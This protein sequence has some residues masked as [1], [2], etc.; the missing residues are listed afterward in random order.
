[1][2]GIVHI[3]KG[4]T[5]V[6]D[7]EH[8]YRA[9][10]KRS[11]PE[12]VFDE[13]RV[14]A[15]LGD[16]RG[17]GV[18]MQEPGF[19]R[20]MMAMLAG[21]KGCRKGKAVRQ[22]IISLESMPDA[23]QAVFYSA[24]GKLPDAAKN[25]MDTFAPGC[26]WVAFVH[27]DRHHPH[28]HVVFENWDYKHGGRRLDLNPQLLSKMQDMKWCAGLGIES[29]K[30]SIGRVIDGQKLD[31][32]G[33]DLS[34]AKTWHER[35][36]LCA[37]NAFATRKDAA[38]ELLHWCAEKKPDKTVESLLDALCSGPLPPGWEVKSKTKS[39]GDLRKPSVKIGGATLRLETFLDVFAA[40]LKP[41]G[42]S[43]EQLRANPENVPSP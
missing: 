24:L 27:Q 14:F 1:M 13:S 25:W 10:A 35:V 37:W 17:A 39:G 19:E 34:T 18:I 42:A 6:K 22:A 31:Q 30:G 2:K 12:R 16:A 5:G 20:G 38:K 7:L 15:V 9:R 11:G 43:L 26:R 32:A 41:V 21:P 40:K 23:T 8:D 4:G 36:E 33:E 28:V 3:C 29:G